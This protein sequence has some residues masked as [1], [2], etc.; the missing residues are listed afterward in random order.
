[1]WR[2]LKTFLRIVVY[3]AVIFCGLLLLSSAAHPR[4]VPGCLI[5]ISLGL[6][7]IF[8]VIGVFW[9]QRWE[10]VTLVVSLLALVV[11][12]A[13]L[14]VP[15]PIAH[16]P[17]KVVPMAERP[18]VLNNVETTATGAANDAVGEYRKIKDAEN[19]K[20]AVASLSSASN[21]LR[22][23][24]ATKL[25][26]NARAIKDSVKSA[27]VSDSVSERVAPAVADAVADAIDK[28]VPAD[29]ANEAA[30]RGL[31]KAATA[32]SEV[33]RLLDEMQLANIAFNAPA[34][35]GYG[36]TIGI[37][38]RL[39]TNKTPGELADMIHE[40]GQR[41][42]SSVKISNEMDARLTGEAF[43]ITAVRPE[44]QAVSASGVTQWNWDI[45]PKQL[46]QQRLHLTLDA[47]V[48]IED[49]ETTYTVQTFDRTIGVNVVW[50]DT[51]LSF[52]GKY[53]QWVC[54]AL[55][56][57]VIAWIA[58]RIFKD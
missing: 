14:L 43:Q 12:C 40:P 32:P 46:G 2:T 18:A 58:K 4:S 54:T 11:G 31:D 33:D 51:A 41:E 22:S 19:K 37:Q 55:V 24:Q 29:L 17:S 28:G 42:T 38:L 34:S 48:R 27:S 13:A 16:G 8:G 25:A 1:M 6:L 53:W 49:H 3:V 52:L 9:R 30:A 45:T 15:R 10:T 57:P 26:G 23:L 21:Q 56:F 7:G 50:P 47:I 35:L 5:G 39:S 44:R 20:R 36:E